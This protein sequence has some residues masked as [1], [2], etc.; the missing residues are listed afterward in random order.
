MCNDT[1]V[2]KV[3][4]SSVS[5]ISCF[6][7]KSIPS[8]VISYFTS[9]LCLV[10]PP[11]V[12]CVIYS[13]CAG[14]PKLCFVSVISSCAFLPHLYLVLVIS[15]VCIPVFVLCQFSVLCSLHY[16]LCLIPV[17]LA[18]L[19]LYPCLLSPFWTCSSNYQSL[20]FVSIKIYVI[21]KQ[22]GS[23]ASLTGECL[24]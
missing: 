18:G 23:R 17:F 22:T 4:L 1:V 16:S 2:M 10:F 24:L 11:F 9:R 14:L 12:N 7:L 8:C 15:L 13:T 21:L 6:I 20:L 5:S 19:V 3:E